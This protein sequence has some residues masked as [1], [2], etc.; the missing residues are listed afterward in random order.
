MRP[1]NVQ[2]ETVTADSVMKSS[3]KHILKSFERLKPFKF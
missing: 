1:G 3:E 2:K